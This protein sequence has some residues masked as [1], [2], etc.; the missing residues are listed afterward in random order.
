MY[1][2][3]F[4]SMIEAVRQNTASDASCFIVPSFSRSLSHLNLFVAVLKHW[5]P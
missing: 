2:M 1:K 3:F 5:T 4:T